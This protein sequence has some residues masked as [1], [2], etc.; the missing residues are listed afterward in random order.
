MCRFVYLLH[1]PI[2]VP[3]PSKGYLCMLFIYPCI[4]LS[5]YSSTYLPTQLSTHL[6]TYR[7]IHLSNRMI[8]SVTLCLYQPMPGPGIRNQ[9][10]EWQT[11]LLQACSK[12][13]HVCV[14]K[15]L[16]RLKNWTINSN[17]V[18][19]FLCRKNWKLISLV[20]KFEPRPI[21]CSCSHHSAKS[22]ELL[23]KDLAFSWWV[24]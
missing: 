22:H 1:L 11:S 9:A 20:L 19:Q 16:D 21:W 17:Y 7:P 10:S 15:L 23:K 8:F 14:S 24:I 13:G 18:P 6:S 12:S 4:H 3:S 2:Y 5:T